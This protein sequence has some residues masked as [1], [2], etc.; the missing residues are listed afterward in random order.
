VRSPGWVLLALAAAACTSEPPAPSVARNVVLVTIDTLRADRLGCY[1]SDVATPHLDRIAAQGALAPEASAHVPLTRPS[2]VSLFTGLLPSQHGIRDNISP[3]VVPDVP[4]LAETFKRAGFATAGFVSSIVLASESGLDRGFDRYSDEF[5]GGRGDAQFLNT[6]QKP[7]DQ[8]LGEATSWLESAPGG[9]LF[10]WIHLYDPHD[11]YEPPEPYASRYAG[12]LYDGEVAWSDDLVGRLDAALERLGL[13]P[14]TLL[15]VTSDHGEGLGEH[16]ESLHGFFAYQTTLRVPLLLRGPGVKAGVRLPITVGLVDLFP[17]LLELAGVPL[18]AGARPAGRSLAAALRGGP[19]PPEKVTYAET[20]VPLLHFGWS[21]LRVVREGKWKYIQAPRP[22][23]YDLEADPGERADLARSRAAQA[24]TMRAALGRFLDDERRAAHSASAGSGSASPDL[25]EKLGAL[26]YLG[27]GGPAQTSTPGADPKDR[28]ED[29]RVVNSLIREALLKLNAGEHRESVRLL[30][31]VASRGIESFEVHYYLARSLLAL[32]SYAEA[33]GHFAKA[34]ERAPTHAA[35]WEGL[36]ECRARLGDVE[37][38]R[39]AL[40]AGQEKLPRDA[41]LRMREAQLL[42]SAARLPEA[43][44]AY[45]SALP[46]APR[47]ARMRVQLGELLRDM[48]ETDQ[49]ILRLREATGLEPGNA[50][51]WNSLG[52]VLGGTGRLSEAEQAFRKAVERDERNHRYTY[53]L[54]LALFRLGR[55]A[56]ARPFFEKAL[57]LEPGFEPAREQLGA[58]AAGQGPRS[59]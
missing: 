46:L 51:Y 38:A 59:G 57:A 47:D 30:R 44:S 9:R 31:Q 22:E 17:T 25:I 12:R 15:V 3:A 40:R 10:A 37:G 54:G 8:T 19:A 45:E 7:G 33:G 29:F 21:D 18:P 2:H 48:G 39:Q 52:M 16:G 1:G 24:E 35:A 41:G 27:G 5:Q 56:D 34:A 36:A 20:L 55:P 23:L 28:I 11:P 43:K 49:A 58:I 6:V 32:K 42:R 53:N 4:L 14:Q 26:G 13:A 50:S